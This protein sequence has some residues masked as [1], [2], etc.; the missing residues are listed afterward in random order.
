MVL[1]STRGNNSS[2]MKYF[3]LNN[4]TTDLGRLQMKN[5]NANIHDQWTENKNTNSFREGIKQEI[6]SVYED[7]L[8][9]IA[10]LPQQQTQKP[11]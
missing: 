6:V 3:H 11:C 5:M 7:N 2:G 1:S 8:H 4:L 9:S 10:G